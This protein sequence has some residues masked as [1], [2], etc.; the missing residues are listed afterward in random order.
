MPFHIRN[1]YGTIALARAGQ[2]AHLLSPSVGDFIDAIAPRD[3][4]VGVS[5]RRCDA[6]HLQVEVQD[7]WI[8]LIDE[9]LSLG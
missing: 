7:R 4:D 5:T 6:F 3:R 8:A 9:R 1:G 2:K